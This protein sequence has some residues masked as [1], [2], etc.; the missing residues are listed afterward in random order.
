[1]VVAARDANWSSASTQTQCAE[2]VLRERVT[3]TDHVS[4]T[5]VLYYKTGAQSRIMLTNVRCDSGDYLN[6]L[7]AL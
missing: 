7:P 1:M 2:E 4:N 3:R 6:I 5:L